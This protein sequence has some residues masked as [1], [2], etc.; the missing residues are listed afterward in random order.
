MLVDV[1]GVEADLLGVQVLVDVAV[2]E[3]GPQL[4]VVYLVAQRQVLYGEPGGA[5]IPRR[6]VLIGAFGNVTNKHRLLLE[7]QGGPV[8]VPARDSV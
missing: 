4:G 7:G 2:I 6:R 5:E 8:A 3:F 1:D